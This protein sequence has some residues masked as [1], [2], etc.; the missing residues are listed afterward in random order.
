[1]SF[2]RSDSISGNALVRL[3]VGFIVGMFVLASATV[4]ERPTSQAPIG[5][6][7]YRA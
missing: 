6:K 2:S 1:M 5:T 4:Q 3:R 7:A